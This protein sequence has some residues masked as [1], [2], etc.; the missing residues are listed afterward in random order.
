[1]MQE[2]SYPNS[3]PI[4]T[5]L[6]EAFPANHSVSQEQE[7]DLTIQE[8]RCF[9]NILSYMS[10]KLLGDGNTVEELSG[11]S[12]IKKLYDLWY[13]QKENTIRTYT[14]EMPERIPLVDNK[15]FKSKMIRMYRI[16]SAR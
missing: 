9:F 16:P 11:D 7:K 3:Y 14:D 5:L 4:L 13:E 1:M 15:E 8:E 10:N 12:R 2:K 6:Q